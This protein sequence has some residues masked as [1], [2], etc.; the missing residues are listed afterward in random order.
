MVRKTM[1]W[2]IVGVAAAVD[3]LSTDLPETKL[4]AMFFCVME[5]LSILENAGRAG[6]PIPRVLRE[7]LIKISNDT[8]EG[9]SAVTEET[10]IK[11]ETKG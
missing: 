9:S 3:P 2:L 5:G 7:A 11:G 1:M 6:V 8:V 10:V 4:T